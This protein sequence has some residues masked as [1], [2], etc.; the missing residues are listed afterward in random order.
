MTELH[1]I[2]RAGRVRRWHTNADLAHTSDPIDGH[3]GRVA[4]IILAL[5]AN[6]S[7]ALLRAALTHDDGEHAVGDIRAPAKDEHPSLS[8]WLDA[9]EAR[10]RKSLWGDDPILT[11]VE[12]KWLYYADRKDA[13]MWAQTHAPHALSGDGWPEA[14]ERLR[15]LEGELIA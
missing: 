1:R 14:I 5:H 11:E 10:A 12:K 8:H 2:F 15:E 7:A 9:E 13:L 4:R 3:S 6:P